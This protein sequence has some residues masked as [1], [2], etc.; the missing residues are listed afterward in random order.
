[1]VKKLLCLKA[2]FIERAKTG[3]ELVQITN[4]YEFT[5]LCIWKIYVREKRYNLSGIEL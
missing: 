3:F 4:Y 1:M 5:N 2:L